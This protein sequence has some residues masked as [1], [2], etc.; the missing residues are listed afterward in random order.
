MAKK[1]LAMA[2]KLG[3]NKPKETVPTLA[4]KT[5]SV[6]AAFNEDEDG[7]PEETS[8][9]AKMKMKGLEGRHK[10]QQDQTPSGKESMVFLK[11]RSYG[12]KI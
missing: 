8:P 2:I 9:E 12:S 5:L 3:S 10:H 11:A 6:K 1:A 4:P 7:E